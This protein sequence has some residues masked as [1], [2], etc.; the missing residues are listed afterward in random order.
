MTKLLKATYQ[1]KTIHVS[2]YNEEIHKGKLFCPSCKNPPLQLTYNNRGF[3]MAWR[4]RGGHNC[5]K[6]TQT[7]HP[8]AD[9]DGRSYINASTNPRKPIKLRIN[10][11]RI[12]VSN[13]QDIG[14]V[15]KS[16][17]R[18]VDRQGDLT[19]NVIRSVA[20]VKQIIEEGGGYHNIKCYFEDKSGRV[21]SF[22]D[23]VVLCHKINKVLQVEQRFVI[24]KVE[25]VIEREERIFINSFFIDN[26][27]ITAI[28]KNEEGHTSRLRK[29]EK[30]YV[31]AFGTVSQRNEGNQLFFLRLQSITHVQ[32]LDESNWEKVFSGCTFYTYSEQLRRN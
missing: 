30:K 8:A 16:E 32:T 31:I 18:N 27:Q 17:S 20:Q 15:D 4:D 25:R 22:E 14:Y 9:R 28:L 11:G 3:F 1:G 21:I 2:E 7:R 12:Q 19:N 29:L 26:I 10:L 24:F 13:N 5:H 6:G 23:M